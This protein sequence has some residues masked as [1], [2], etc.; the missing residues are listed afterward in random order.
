MSL[1][2]L[3]NPA[4][5]H[6]AAVFRCVLMYRPISVQHARLDWGQTGGHGVAGG[7]GAGKWGVRVWLPHSQIFS[8][9]LF[10]FISQLFLSASS[11]FSLSICITHSSLSSHLGS[12]SL[13]SQ[14]FN[15][16]F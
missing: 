9:P 6:K 11:R 7:L 5:D 1:I 3:C 16:I 13:F 10:F 12:A 14:M 15:L 4:R 8:D 2:Y